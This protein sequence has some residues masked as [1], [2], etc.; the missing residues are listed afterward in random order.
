MSRFVMTFA[1]SCVAA[2][3]A[4]SQVAVPERLSPDARAAVLRIADSARVAGLP[5][6]PILSKAAE[7]VLKGADDARIVRAAR[8]LFAE[9]GD[10]RAALPRAS[11]S[12]LTAAAS[13]IHAG[14]T[15][16]MLRELAAA[17]DARGGART[18]A[19]VAI[20]FISIADLAASGVAADRATSAMSQLL[21]RGAGDRDIAVFR[22]AVAED[23]AA[24]R[25]PAD[26]VATR[27]PDG[28]G[29]GAT[30]LSAPRRPTSP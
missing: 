23:I 3:A 14:A 8:V 19:D 22:A 12:V 29:A 21:R 30:V 28:S 15:Q 6:D 20:A 13:A 27:M 17:A 4:Q 25:S 16:A 2:T 10:A 26:A 5:A 24:G 18:D 9:L 11:A 1:L 7:G